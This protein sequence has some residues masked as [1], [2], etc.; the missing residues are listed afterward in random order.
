MVVTNT[1]VSSVY[2]QICLELHT[3]VYCYIGYL[4][5]VQVFV[6]CTFHNELQN[7]NSMAGTQV[8]IVN[9]EE[10]DTMMK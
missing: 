1:C 6:Y 8:A 5:I 3:L 4:K 2:G 7:F 10:E 9:N